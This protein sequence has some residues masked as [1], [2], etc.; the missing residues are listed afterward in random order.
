MYTYSAGFKYSLNKA[1][2]DILGE[3]GRITTDEAQ[4]IYNRF[5]CPKRLGDQIDS[6]GSKLSREISDVVD[7]V[8]NSL[9]AASDYAE[10]LDNVTASLEQATT[11]EELAE[12]IAHII[13]ST[14]QTASLNR[15]L[16]DKLN[17]S[18]QQ[19][20]GLQESL[21]AI[22]YESL[23]DD[24]TTLANRRHFDESI[25][26]AVLNMLAKRASRCRCFSPISITSSSSTTISDIKLEIRFCGW[27]A[28]R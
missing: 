10:S 7:I 12:I 8:T 24:L 9:T 21:E 14:N 4:N 2:N 23:T 6:V 1:V 5:L 28:C 16:E 17:E 18:R 11:R 19:I 26:R 22:R 20:S 25:D 15:E 27:W 13:A 3:K